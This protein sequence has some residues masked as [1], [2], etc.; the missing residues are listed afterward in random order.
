MCLL[1]FYRPG[2]LPDLDALRN[3]AF[4]NDDGH[5]YA[6]VTRDRKLIVG[7]GLNSDAMIEEFNKVRRKHPH[8]PAMFHSRY[9]TG[10]SNDLLNVHPFA[11]GGDSRTVIAHNG[12]FPAS[13]QPG[14]GESRC[15]TRIV[16]E[17]FLPLIGPLSQRKH[18][19]VVEKWMGDNNKIV[20]LTTDPKYKQPWF[21]L[22]EDAG[23]WEEDTW[24]SNS[25]WKTDWR[26]YS[27]RSSSR[28][29]YDEWEGEGAWVKGRD[30]VWR[31]A[32]TSY[33]DG[34]SE[35]SQEWP[36]TCPVCQ[37]VAVDDGSGECAY[38]GWC[39]DCGEMPGECQC[40]GTVNIQRAGAG[41]VE[42]ITVAMLRRMAAEN[43]ECDGSDDD[44]GSPWRFD[45]P[46]Q[47]ALPAGT[48]WPPDRETAPF[49][50]PR[51]GTGWPE[52]RDC[53][54][55]EPKGGWVLD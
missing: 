26:Y 42:S 10:G 6:I 22:N 49:E 45:P 31:P 12:V 5:G 25:G 35:R 15:D 53:M 52:G 54:T 47:L 9:G 24:Y 17:D 55:P 21:I 39:F 11:V 27:F 28:S 2:V 23:D 48:G 13:V 16:A 33:A 3:G 18:R 8:G 7:R 44:N 30:G 29:W 34:T 40:Y 51:T 36:Q 37:N 50:S 32:Q 41:S 46:S 4:V 43:D 19:L 20:L 1:T 14:K 38:C